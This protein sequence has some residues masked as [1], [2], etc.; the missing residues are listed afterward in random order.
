[1][2]SY[3][4]HSQDNLAVPNSHLSMQ[5]HAAVESEDR[6]FQPERWNPGKI[7]VAQKRWNFLNSSLQSGG[8]HCSHCYFESSP[9]RGYSSS[10]KTLIWTSCEI[11]RLLKPRAFMRSTNGAS[12]LKTLI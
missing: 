2:G 9:M 6:F 5:E 8:V 4:C 1:L 10:L 11:V 7:L 3:S 12:I